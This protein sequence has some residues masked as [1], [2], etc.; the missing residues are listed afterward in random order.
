MPSRASYKFMVWAG[1]IT[2]CLLVSLP[3]SLQAQVTGTISGYVKDPS[4]GAIPGAQV[5]ATSV[6]KGTTQTAQSNSEGFYNFPALQPDTYTLTTEK[7]GF[8]RLVRTGVTL[9]VNQNVRVDLEMPLGQVRQEVTVSSAPP[10]VNTTSSTVSGLVEDRRIVDLPLNGRNVIGLASI[11]PGVTGVNA[12]QSLSDARSGPTMNVNGGLFNQNDFMFDGAY[13]VNP[14]RNT[15]LNYPPP[16]AVQEFRILT[17]NFNAEFGRN[18]GSEIQVVT[19]SGTNQFHGDAWEFLRN[20]ALN[21]RNFFTDT[22]PGIKQNQFGAAAGGPIKKDKIFFFGSY[23]GLRDRPQAVASTVLVPSSAERMGDFSALPAGS[24][25]DPTDPL[26]GQPLKDSSGASC[27]SNNMIN[28]NCLSPASQKLLTFV[29]QSAS[30]EV[31][32]L[33]ASPVNDDM[34]LGRVD[35]NMSSK[36][37][38]F[39]HI[40]IDRNSSSDAFSDGSLVVP[41][42]TGE[43]FVEQTVMPTLN[44]TYTFSPSLINQLVVSYMRNTSFQSQTHSIN[45]SD[46]GVNM[47]Q[48][49]PTGDIY[50]NV[51]GF[52]DFGG[53]FTTK[54]LNNNYQVKDT[55]TWMKGKHEFRFGGEALWLHFVQRFIGSPNFSYDGSR[56]GNPMADFM[57]GAFSSLSLDFGVRDNDD[58]ETA[59]SVFFQDQYKVTRRLTLTYGLRWEPYLPWIDQHDRLNTFKPGQQSKVVPD[60][61]PGILFPGDPGIPRGMSPSDLN[62][63]APRVG[64]AWDVFGDGKTSVRGGY[65]VFYDSIKADALSQ[66]NAPFAGF[67]NSFNGLLDNPFSS[68][69][70]PTPP[71]QP[72]GQF[73]C[74]AISSYPGVDC[75]LFPL[76]VSGLFVDGN[77]VTPYYQAANL[78]VER[79]L[80]PSI[81]LRTGYVG[82][83][84][85]KI[86]AWRNFNPGRPINDPVTGAPPSLNNVN[87]RVIFEPGILA[88]TFIMLGNDS[89][90]WY[91]SWQTE[92][93]KQFSH[94][95]SLN[96]SYVL[97]KSMDTL[98]RSNNVYSY[99]YPDPFNLRSNRGVSDFDRRHAFV[100]SWLWSPPIKFDNPFENS[101][102]G[103]WTLTGITTIQSGTPLLFVSGQDVALDGVSGDERPDL[104]GQPIAISHPNRAAEVAQFFNPAAFKFPAPG[105]YGDAGRGILYGPAFSS[106]D[107]S[108][109]KNFSFYRER[110]RVQFRSE[111]FNV[112][113]QVN[114]HNPTSSLASGG[115]GQ[116]RGA[117]DAR[118]IQFALKF[119]W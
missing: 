52:F 55:L 37:Q 43:T 62:N 39:G 44:D 116:I 92:V 63:F 108:A 78:T 40:Y 97:S 68:A 24:L 115:F 53:G 1:M 109:I 104:S 59:P 46:L 9:T 107:F 110:Y 41:D 91:H 70:L 98:P 54:F 85:Q 16:D 5:S 21:A 79:Q 4:G 93:V 36:H 26:T 73:G 66:E 47:P 112:F 58:L 105:T 22:V 81:M 15:G 35:F 28:P 76:P 95:F 64:F 29:P 75:P 83:I 61:P 11:L 94:G 8:Q 103:G 118:V 96:A 74:T 106:T 84:G 20:N 90:S 14:S 19:K 88:P 27:V 30:G 50:T 100:A 114:F 6:S 71:V 18:V 12:P 113:N 3:M 65:G 7:S 80:T 23:Q 69:G 119:L 82:K 72:S 86:D 102:L 45:P 77:V 25:Q 31:A 101:A 57:L 10:L 117:G 42:F 111:F 48:Y 32:S 17:S 51:S 87:D 34:Y 99:G 56:S 60:A 2:V 13:F 89:R 67:G 38:L 33:G 49:T